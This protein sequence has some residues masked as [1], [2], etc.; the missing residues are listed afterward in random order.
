MSRGAVGEVRITE[1]GEWVCFWGWRKEDTVCGIMFEVAKY[2][3]QELFVL[4]FV[5]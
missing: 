4:G 1:G 2:E 3:V 5:F